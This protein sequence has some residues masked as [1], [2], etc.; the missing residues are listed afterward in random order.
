M[1]KALERMFLPPMQWTMPEIVDARQPNYGSKVGIDAT[2]KRAA[3]GFTRQRSP[4]LAM[5]KGVEAKVD[6]VWKRLGIE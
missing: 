6:T 2:R 1:G 5:D 4:M 3:E